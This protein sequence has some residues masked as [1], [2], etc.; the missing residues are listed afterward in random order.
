M[1]AHVQGVSVDYM[2]ALPRNWGNV[3]G[4]YLSKGNDAFLKPLGWLPLV[5]TN[6]TLGVN[7]R[8]DTDVVTVEEDR[9]TLVHRARDMTSAEISEHNEVSLKWLRQQRDEK[10]VD[11]DWTQASDYPSAT[12]SLAEVEKAQW[13]TYRQALR[14]LP[15]TTEDLSHPVWPTPPS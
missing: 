9:V 4:L 1:Y 15:A 5:E 8:W 14:D 2:G 7:Q 3:S 12:F 11:S 10:L 13:A 6:M